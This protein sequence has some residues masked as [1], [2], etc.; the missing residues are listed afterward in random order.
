MSTFG[1]DEELQ[2]LRTHALEGRAALV[3]GAPGIGR[4]HLLR[5]LAAQLD[6]AGAPVHRV[7]GGDGASGVALAPFAP[8]VVEHLP[9]AVGE[10][11]SDL[12]V[13]GR[14]PAVLAPTG[15]VLVVDDLHLLDSASQVLVAHLARAGLTLITSAP[16]RGDLSRTLRDEV[17]GASGRRWSLLDLEPLN[18]DS[19]LAQAAEEAGDELTAPAGAF[20]VVHAEGNP[21]VAAELVRGCEV[22]LTSYGAELG[23]LEVSPVLEELV[24]ARLARVGDQARATL[25]LLATAG[26][27]PRDIGASGAVEELVEAGLAEV[28][29]TSVRPRDLL[30][31]RVRSAAL[32]PRERRA[33]AEQVACT[34]ESRAEW[35][36]VE[37]LMRQRA[38]LPVDTGRR[39]RAAERAAGARRPEDV[40]ELL[41]PVLDDVA[42]PRVDLLL[43]S[44][45]SALERT[46]DAEPLLERAAAGTDV[47]TRVRAGQELGLLHA[48]RRMDPAAAVVRVE[49]V[50]DTVP[51]ADARLPLEVDLVKWRLMAGQ[52]PAAMPDVP[53][54]S[55]DV[56]RANTAL[57]G[58]MVAALDGDPEEARREVAAGMAA[59]ARTDAV[60]A[61]TTDLLRLSAYLADT[62][63]GRLAE[64]ERRAQALR[65]RAA[66][67]AHPSLGMWEYAA[68]EMS[69][70]AGQFRRA[71]VLASRA[72]RHL[73]WRDFTGLRPSACALLAAAVARQGRPGRAAALLQDLP[74]VATADVKVAL[75][76]GRVEAEQ[77]AR[78][79]DPA[80]AADRLGQVAERAIEE[81]HRHLGLLATD[82]SLMLC[83][84]APQASA[85]LEVLAAAADLTPVLGLLSERAAA[86]LERDADRLLA[87]GERLLDL[88]L[89]GRA[90][91]AFTAA[92]DLMQDTGRR[93]GSARAHRR[94]V[95][96]LTETSGAAWPL[97]SPPPVLSA[98]EFD[99]ARLAAARLRSREIAEQVG[100]SVRTVDNHLARV[101]RKLG[102][103]GRDELGEALADLS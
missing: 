93:D 77:L 37:C 87:C 96:V 62:F 89:V 2:W 81:S 47:P 54:P 49:E 9:H 40:V 73:A 91:H 75:H 70:H 30:V 66:R 59:A 21:R 56:A 29:G 4:T 102:I 42:S 7:T 28:D 55:D 65:R 53:D 63:D 101:Y 58:A 15:L 33:A 90:A 52:P 100:L 8:L 12:E 16:G 80:A 31:A 74:A 46:D 67:T 68:A 18:D 69:L 61:H 78:A 45:L 43:G 39:L 25:D 14:L 51:D 82:E 64:A 5:A 24:G 99:V 57:L 94:A 11:V 95:L 44:A 1:R 35:V 76:V 23:D 92:S 60:P 86:L 72:V 85:R 19:I 38:G 26:L 48:V 6:S 13:F 88:G 32:N 20:V 36:H 83:P 84:D 10:Q 103:S 79:G 98:R 27:A 50:A 71:R 34:M 41:Q 3:T 97:P 17:D 22:H